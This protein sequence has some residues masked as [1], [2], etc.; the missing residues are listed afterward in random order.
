[1]CAVWLGL[2]CFSWQIEPSSVHQS[3]HGAGETQNQRSNSWPFT[4]NPG[5]LG[6]SES[7]ESAFNAEDM[8]LIPGSGRSPG[9]R[10][11]WLHHS[12][13]LA[14]RIPWTKGTLPGYSPCGR[15]E[16]DTTE[17]LTLSY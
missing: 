7:K 3:A 13:I 10:Y 5:F 9:E 1:M 8:G 6:G 15:K 14:W 2:D 4:E 16:S 12:S 11:G 17:Q